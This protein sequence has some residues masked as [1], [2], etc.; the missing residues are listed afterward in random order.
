LEKAPQLLDYSCFEFTKIQDSIG[1]PLFDGYSQIIFFAYCIPFHSTGASYRSLGLEWI[2]L[3][4]SLSFFIWG[5]GMLSFRS[6]DASS[7]PREGTMPYRRSDGFTLIE[8]LVV[9]AIIAILIGLLLPAVQEVREAASRLQCQN[10]LKQMG[11]AWHNHA[12]VHGVFP[13][14]GL[15]WTLNRTWNG[16]E[17][18]LYQTQAWGWGYQILPFIEQ[19]NLWEI[20][21]GSLPGD[22]SAGPLGDIE[23]ASTPVKIYNCPTL[24]T[25]VVFPYSQAGWSPS[26]GRR[27]VGDYVANAGTVNGL[28]DGPLVPT[29]F[30]VRITDIINGTANVMMIGEKYLDREIAQFSSDCNDDQGW[31]DGW[32]NDTICFADGGGNTA[33][34]PI[35]DGSIGTC[36]LNFG[37]P[38]PVSMQCVLCDGSVRSISFRAAQAPFVIFCSRN[39][40][41]VLDMSSF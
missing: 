32:D 1:N 6:R 29:G 34:V 3:L 20:P 31:T 23:V 11:I 24:R 36:G 28:N 2:A 4:F 7:R 16:T 37:S 41:L 26:V 33:M 17:P 30:S 9:I 35:P 22:A 19:G 18:G 38:H 25:G 21:P 8:L 10:N 5:V 27:A 40:E 13:S 15:S 39:N 14:G 12:D